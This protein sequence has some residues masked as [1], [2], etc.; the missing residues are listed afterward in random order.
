MSK[1]YMKAISDT[2]KNMI[3]TRGNK[4]ITIELYYDEENRKRNI[5]LKFAHA[6]GEKGQTKFLKGEPLM[7]KLIMYGEDGTFTYCEI[8]EDHRV[9]CSSLKDVE[10]KKSSQIEWELLQKD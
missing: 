3:T 5:L 9:A 7:A 8:S 4:S 10:T 1:L 2:R 6:K